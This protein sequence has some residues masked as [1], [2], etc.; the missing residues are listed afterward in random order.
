MS[1]SS[2]T[3]LIFFILITVILISGLIIS[4]YLLRQETDGRPVGSRSP[5]SCLGAAGLKAA[6]SEPPTTLQIRGPARS[7]GYM[8]QRD[9]LPASPLRV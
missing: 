4:L 2:R 3:G 8:F 6:G 1:K 7:S 5:V 9:R